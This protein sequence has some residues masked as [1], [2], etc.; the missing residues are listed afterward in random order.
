MSSQLIL[1]PILKDLDPSKDESLIGRTCEVHKEGKW[2][3][4]E[5]ISSRKHPTGTTKVIVQVMGTNE[6]R[7]YGVD[8]I[9]L[10]PKAN[11]EH[12]TVGMKV[13]AIWKDDGLWYNAKIEAL[14]NGDDLYRVLYDGF[15]GEPETV[16]ADQIREPII[17]T[18]PATQV[19]DKEVKTY[20]TPAG[21][22]IP[23]KLKINP[24]KDSEKVMED[25]KRKIHH[26][27]SQQRQ[28]RHSEELNASK[29]KWQQFQSKLGGVRR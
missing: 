15:D 4:A 19:A 24:S 5:V 10:L 13:Q 9:K 17:P 12:F 16:K 26:I 3:N 23:E 2:Y 1:E 29:S 20:V 8:D 14:P 22:I 28:E 18:R 7:E 27:K 21:Y 25:K 11:P 6:G